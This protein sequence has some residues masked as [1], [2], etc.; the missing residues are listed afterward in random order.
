MSDKHERIMMAAK[1]WAAASWADG[2]ITDEEKV[3]MAAIIKL[4][5]LSDDQR[6]QA[7]AWLDDKVDLDDLDVAGLPDNRKHAIYSAAAHITTV[8]R[9]VAFG[10][11]VFL[12][13]LRQALGIDDAT[14]DRLHAQVPGLEPGSS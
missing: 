3:G 8:D 4:A 6:K 1:L 2:V 12:T 11:K 9:E 5:D 13:R 7:M 10:E 14:A